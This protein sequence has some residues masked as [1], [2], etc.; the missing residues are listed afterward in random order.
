MSE[1]RNDGRDGDDQLGARDRLAVLLA[2]YSSMRADQINR[3]HSA[4][5]LVAAGIAALGLALQQGVGWL[6][7]F[8]VLLGAIGFVPLRDVQQM[9]LRVM[10][11][12]QEI[13]KRVGEEGLMKWQHSQG[14]GLVGRIMR[15]LGFAKGG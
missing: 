8:A 13:N 9:N 10:Q 14:G 5:T 3:A 11:L 4:Y 1:D 7:A 2:E 12:E 15:R 6:V